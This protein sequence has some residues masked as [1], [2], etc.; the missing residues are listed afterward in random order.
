[1][2]NELDETRDPVS[3]EGRDANVIQKQLGV[4]LTG[5]EK[6]CEV[7]TWFIFIVGG[8]VYQFRKAKAREYYGKLQQKIQAAASQIDNYMEQRVQIL[9]NAA[10]L[11]D[12]AI[13]L[14]KSVLT[15]VAAYRGG[16]DPKNDAVR[17]DVQGK[18]DGMARS[19]NVAFEA[20]PDIQAHQEIADCLQQ[21]AYLQKE[22]T[23]ARELYNDAVL[24]WNQAIYTFLA[25]KSVAAKNGYTTRIPFT[26]S[27][28]TK[29]KARSVFF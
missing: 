28:E 2:V 17:N 13:D 29:E 24:E 7:G 10:K 22:I 18:L 21:N 6:F 11:L 19:I 25:K 12:K 16:A 1:M 26:A 23:S 8:V 3:E 5:F 15:E 14:D 4:Q 9:S 27:K 20:Y